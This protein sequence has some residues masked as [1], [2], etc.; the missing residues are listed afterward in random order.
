MDGPVTI[1]GDVKLNGYTGKLLRVNL[2]NGK[3]TVEEIPESYLKDYIGGSGLAV[4]YLYDEIPVDSDVFDENNKLFF[5]VGPLNGKMFPTSGRFVVSCRSPLTG[6]W[7]DSSA[8]GRFAYNLKRAGYDAVSVEGKSDKPVYLMIDNDRIEIRDASMAWGKMVSEAIKGIFDDSGL[9]KASC[10]AI[11]P[12]GEKLVKMACMIGDTGKAA[13][14]GGSGALM[15]SK[16]LKAVIVY[17]NQEMQVSDEAAWKDLIKELTAKI[18]A[19]PVSEALKNFGTSVAMAM[20]IQSGDAPIKNWKD[21]A[22]DGFM[23]ISGITMA[24][25]I[26]RKHEPQCLACPIRCCR[27]VEIDDGPYQMKGEGPEYETM[28]SFGS[29]CL[30]DNLESIAYANMLCNEYGMDTISVGASVSFAMEAYEKGIISKEDTGGVA[31]QWGSA[32]AILAII[33]QIANRESLGALLGEGVRTAAEELGH[34]AADFAIEVKGLELPMHDPRAFFAFGPTYATSPRG[35]CHTHGY[36]GAYDG[37]GVMP[38]AGLDQPQDPHAMTGKGFLAK[39]VQDFDSVV[40]SAVIC[41]FAT[42][43]I[44]P[45]EMARALT[46]A[47]GVPFNAQDVLKTGERIFN[48]QRAFNSR[49]GITSADDKLPARLLTSKEGSPVA[50]FVPNI[51]EQLAEYYDLRDWEVDGK[52][53]KSKL[54]EIGLDFVIGDLYA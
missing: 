24:K 53:S 27:Y 25:T 41:L 8:S 21:G 23:N 34:G 44:G 49:F 47:T 46:I 7:L 6:I 4:R 28:G 54:K 50:G 11:G 29:M 1:K 45:T 48:L 35:A 5:S 19:H 33:R 22:W 10:F 42:Y 43:S 14:R 17:G 40:Q 9:K 3:I 15:G 18:N 52:P 51:K 20:T 36:V 30:N 13:G 37:Q 12:A 39:I 26:L 32:E 31:L 16:K 38:E 2:T